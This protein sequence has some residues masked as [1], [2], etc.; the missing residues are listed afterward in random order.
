MTDLEAKDN[1]RIVRPIIVKDG[2]LALGKR[3]EV[4]IVNNLIMKTTKR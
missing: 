1:K 2:K 3:V 4:T